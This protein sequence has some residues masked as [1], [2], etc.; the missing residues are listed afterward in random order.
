MRTN[1]IALIELRG[2]TLGTILEDSTPEERFQNET[3]RP[4]LKFQNDLLLAVFKNYAVQQ[5][6]VFFTLSLEK[7]T[8]Y[9][10]KAIQRDMKFRNALK[11]MIVGLFTLSEY[12]IYIQN[13]S[14]LNKRMMTMLIERYKSQL[15]LLVLE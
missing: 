5:K 9:I 13:S 14:K 11:G 4:I 10:D 1:E 2:A 8:E 12:N 7:K 15:Q 6:S 3:L